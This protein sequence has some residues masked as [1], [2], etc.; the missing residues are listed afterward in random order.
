MSEESATI[1]LRQG[2]HKIIL[3]YF[4]MLGGQ[5]LILSWKGP[6]FE[7]EEIPESTLLH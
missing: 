7:K 6:G 3:K 5:G 1:A 2:K 4:Q